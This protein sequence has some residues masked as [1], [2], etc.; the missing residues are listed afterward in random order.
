MGES[1]RMA[2]ITERD[3][4]VPVIVGHTGAGIE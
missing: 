4:E 1:A 2:W 3:F